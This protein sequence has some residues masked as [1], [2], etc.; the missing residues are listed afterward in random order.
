MRVVLYS[1]RQSMSVPLGTVTLDP[2]PPARLVIDAPDDDSRRFVE[3]LVEFATP[4]TEATPEFL[5]YLGGRY[6]GT[7]A[8]A[9]FEDDAPPT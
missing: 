7:G 6:F 1:P 8:Y 9:V 3:H 4:P 2:G 5:R